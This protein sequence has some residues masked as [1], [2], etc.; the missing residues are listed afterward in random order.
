MPEDARLARIRT[1]F[2]TRAA[3]YDDGR[4]H[5]DLA[6]AVA[7][8]VNLQ[9]V[10]RVLDVGTGTGLVLRGIRHEDAAADLTGVDLSPGMLAKAR[11][12]LPEAQW[13]EADAARLPIATD[14][15]DLVTCVTALHLFPDPH[16]ALAE[17][18]RVLRTGGHVV[19]ATFGVNSRRPGAQVQHPLPVDHQSF[20][21][22]AALARMVTPHGFLP[23][24]STSWT[25]GA[26]SVLISEFR[27]VPAGRA[28]LVLPVRVS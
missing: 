22:P 25:D 10:H 12:H 28:D 19:T 5:R 2:D 17:W 23:A 7:H 18:R 15:I 4:F 13:L 20:E 1:A 24:R 16:A 3:D 26:H 21:T 14:S 9:N 11:G 8:F 27:M 6:A